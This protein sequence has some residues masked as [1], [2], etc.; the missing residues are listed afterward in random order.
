MQEQQEHEHNENHEH[1][2]EHKHEHMEGE[3][4]VMYYC[5]MKCEGDKT[6]SK[7]GKCPVCEMDLEKVE[8]NG[9]DHTDHN[10]DEHHGHDH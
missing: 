3:H 2:D 8:E 1:I 10:H 9:A 4:T 5:P 6:Y 7:P